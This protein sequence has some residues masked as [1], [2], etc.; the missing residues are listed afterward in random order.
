MYTVSIKTGSL[1]DADTHAN[2]YIQLLSEAVDSCE[3]K[4][5]SD[6]HANDFQRGKW[7]YYYLKT[8]R[9][10]LFIVEHIVKKS[11]L[12]IRQPAISATGRFN[13]YLTIIIQWK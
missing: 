1:P 8:L 4:L 10:I 11:K 9:I 13:F 2:V 3:Y 5:D 7:V 12:S 6:N